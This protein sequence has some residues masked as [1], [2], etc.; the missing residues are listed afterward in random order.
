MLRCTWKVAL[1]VLVS[2][3]AAASPIVSSGGYWHI[4]TWD[5]DVAC[6]TNCS[7]DQLQYANID[8]FDLNGT[9]GR[10]HSSQSGAAS[11]AVSVQGL[12]T[13]VAHDR[14]FEYN[15]TVARSLYASVAAGAPSSAFAEASAY[16]YGYFGFQLS[17]ASIY[18]GTSFYSFN[19]GM[20][21]N[22]GMILGPGIYETFFELEDVPLDLT[23][24]RMRA[25]QQSLVSDI[26]SF[27]FR[28]TS[29]PEPGTLTLLGAGLLGVVAARRRRT[30]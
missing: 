16:V 9:S 11:A 8:R 3:P 29:V 15:L 23:T 12:G 26:G 7:T 22:E 5:T 14:L 17:E 18:S 4:N 25:G 1:V 24:S 19:R 28:V 20:T 27:T 21:I 13:N 2:G 6:G 30:N 10:T